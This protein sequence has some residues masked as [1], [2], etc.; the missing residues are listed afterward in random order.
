M[1]KLP[2][3][4]R[5]TKFGQYFHTVGKT[6]R[7]DG[8]LTGRMFYLGKE[9]TTAQARLDR[10]A[11]EWASLRGQGHDHWTEESLY[12]LESEGVISRSKTQ[13]IKAKDAQELVGEI[14]TDDERKP[15]A[16]EKGMIRAELAV[17]C[18]L[19]SLRKFVSRYDYRSELFT[20]L[21]KRTKNGEAVQVAKD[22]LTMLGGAQG[23][24]LFN[25]N[26]NGGMSITPPMTIDSSVAATAA[27][28]SS[29]MN[30][31]IDAGI[32]DGSTGGV[33]DS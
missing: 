19:L 20:Q 9:E 30:A 32:L 16:D 15:F 5:S 8:K 2:K 17:P 23:Q 21:M 31:L 29:A 12:K 28:K 11:M 18:L 14:L 1:K 6:K 24:A 7:I 3:L 26:V 27:T 25:V 33:D 4:G 13:V 22:I 10:I